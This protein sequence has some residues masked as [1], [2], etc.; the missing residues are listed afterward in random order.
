MQGG[1]IARPAIG[2]RVVREAGQ[3]RGED[4]QDP[5]DERDVRGDGLPEDIEHDREEHDPDRCVGQDRMQRM[6]EPA[7]VEEV[8]NAGHPAEQPV[9]QAVGPRP[10]RLDPAILSVH[11]ANEPPN[12]HAPPP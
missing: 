9:Q 11:Q 5:D 8:S 7:A 12:D 6:P 10:E 2:V 3:R 4:C 1:P